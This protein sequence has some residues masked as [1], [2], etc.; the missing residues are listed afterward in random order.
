MSIN[1]NIIR[2]I[3][4]RNKA[5]TLVSQGLVSLLFHV[6]PVIMSI[7][8]HLTRIQE[9]ISFSQ[10]IILVNSIIQNTPAQA[11]VVVL[12]QKLGFLDDIGVVGTSYLCGYIKRNKDNILSKEGNKFKIDSVLWSIYANFTPMYNAFL[13]EFV[14]DSVAVEREKQAQ[15]NRQG[16]VCQ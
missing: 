7:M 11:D 16:N 15:M 8:I 9:S 10:G 2:Q 1:A 13:A 6:E 12:K 4:K 5:F 3:I 14:D